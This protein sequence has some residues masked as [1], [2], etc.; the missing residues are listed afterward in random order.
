MTLTIKSILVL[1]WLDAIGGAPHVEHVHRVYS[2]ESETTI[3][4]SLQSHVWKNITPLMTEIEQKDEVTRISECRI[5]DKI[6]CHQ[7]TASRSRG[8]GNFMG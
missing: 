5:H 4:A 6:Q 2:K 1:D 3:L 7:I 8:N